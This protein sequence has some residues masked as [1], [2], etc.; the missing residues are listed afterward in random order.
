[1]TRIIRTAEEATL[2]ADLELYG[3]LEAPSEQQKWRSTSVRR[4]KQSIRSSE[5][6]QIQLLDGLRIRGIR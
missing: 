3:E 4:E 5:L 2:N 1:M 6:R